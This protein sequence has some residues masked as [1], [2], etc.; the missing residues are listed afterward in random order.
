MSDMHIESDLTRFELIDYIL[1]MP[2]YRNNTESSV[3]SM[4]GWVWMRMDTT[5]HLREAVV[6]AINHFAETMYNIETGGNRLNL[7][8]KEE[9]DDELEEVQ[10]TE[11]AALI[12]N[13]YSDYCEDPSDDMDSIIMVGEAL[14]ELIPDELGIFELETRSLVGFTKDSETFCFIF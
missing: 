8:I 14:S 5:R 12:E 9:D 6:I 13:L 10:R 7:S 2:A 3:E 11:L 4:V 1:Q